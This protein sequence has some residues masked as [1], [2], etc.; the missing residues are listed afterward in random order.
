ME[1]PRKIW[2]KNVEY[3]FS[4]WCSYPF[5]LRALILNW[6]N[7]RK[8][9]L[10]EDWLCSSKKMAPVLGK[11]RF[12][13]EEIC[14]R[15]WGNPSPTLGKI[16]HRLWENQPTDFGEVRQRLWENQPPTLGKSV[17]DFGK[18]SHRLWENQPPILG[19]SVTDFGENPSLIL[20]KSATDFGEMRHRFWGNPL[21]ILGTS[22]TD[23]G[24][25][26]AR[27]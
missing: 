13:F 18:I 15:L 3:S 10:G 14:H 21:P 7:S 8:H 26:L 24:E 22:A 4:F 17:T 27:F 20:R 11:K 5:G 25:K 6:S 1:N 16:R 23:F 9:V 2:R 19:K 12:G